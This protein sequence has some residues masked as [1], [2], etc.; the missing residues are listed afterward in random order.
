MPV[1]A[2]SK[3]IVKISQLE[4]NLEFYELHNKLIYLDNG[5]LVVTLRYCTC[6]ADNFIKIISPFFSK[7]KY[8]NSE[9]IK[10]TQSL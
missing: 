9:L 10:S 5:L 3:I 4:I 7:F 8:V 1:V 6:G 2:M